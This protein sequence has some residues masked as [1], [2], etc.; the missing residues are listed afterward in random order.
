MNFLRK[1]LNLHT[2]E[3]LNGKL[4]FNL[5]FSDLPGPLSFYTALESNTI[6][7]INFAGSGGTSPSLCVRP[8]LTDSLNWKVQDKSLA[9]FINLWGTCKSNISHQ[10][11][12]SFLHGLQLF[13]LIPNFFLHFSILQPPENFPTN[14]FCSK[15]AV[16]DSTCKLL[17]KF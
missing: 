6:F 11:N 2:Y 7:Y 9:Q 12:F 14:R 8:S 15:F 3:N 4:I 17:K 10:T 16:W 5:F 13:F 1:F